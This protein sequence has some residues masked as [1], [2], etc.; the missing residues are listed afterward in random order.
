MATPVRDAA[1]IKWRL[2]NKVKSQKTAEKMKKKRVAERQKINTGENQE[3]Q[4][5][6]KRIKMKKGLG[7]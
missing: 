1:R 3:K 7:V 5:A 4:P 6:G 2:S